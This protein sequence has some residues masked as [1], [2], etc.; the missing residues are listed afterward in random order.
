MSRKCCEELGCFYGDNE[1]TYGGVLINLNEMPIGTKF[2]VANGCWEGSIGMVLNTKGIKIL[3]ADTFQKLGNYSHQRL[4]FDKLFVPDEFYNSLEF[5]GD[6]IKEDWFIF[7][8][9][10]SIY[11]IRDFLQSNDLQ[12]TSPSG[13]AIDVVSEIHYKNNTKDAEQERGIED[14]CLDISER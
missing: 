9:G 2:H 4:W 14:A 11:E 6:S 10:T 12:M 8:K 3:G 7:E 13:K 1:H 5:D